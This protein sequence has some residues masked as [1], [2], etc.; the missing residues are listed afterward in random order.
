MNEE[1]R[2]ASQRKEKGKKE[3]REA[4]SFKYCPIAAESLPDALLS[5]LLGGSNPIESSGHVKEKKF[6]EKKRRNPSAG[7]NF[8]RFH[9]SFTSVRK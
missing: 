2:K 8:R 9:T 4:R 7:N 6:A 3:G 5:F 1:G